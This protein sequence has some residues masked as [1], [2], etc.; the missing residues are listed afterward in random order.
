MRLIYFSKYQEFYVDT[1]NEKETSQKVDGF[2]DNLISIGNCN[3][4]LLLREYS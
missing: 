2:L 4:S 3:I 1:K